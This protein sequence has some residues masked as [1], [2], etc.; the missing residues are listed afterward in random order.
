MDQE[1]IRKILDAVP[2]KGE[3]F[4][5]EEGFFVQWFYNEG[6]NNLTLD[7]FVDLGDE[8]LLY[9]HD[10]NHLTK[11]SEDCKATLEDLDKL[12]EWLKSRP[13]EVNS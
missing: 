11:Q 2:V 10:Y 3:V 13:I 1:T 5:D 7:E 8:V 4:E 12:I 6:N 9:G